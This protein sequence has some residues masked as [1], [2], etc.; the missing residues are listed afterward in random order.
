[1]VN[2]GVDAIV[3][4][5]VVNGCRRDAARQY[6]DAY[7]EYREACRNIE[8]HG[9]IVQHPRTSNPITNPYVPVRDRALRKLQGMRGVNA[10]ELVVRGRGPRHG[11]GAAGRF[12]PMLQVDRGVDRS[13]W[14]ILVPRFFR[15]GRIGGRASAAVDSAV[16]SM[17]RVLIAALAAWWL[18]AGAAL[19]ADELRGRVVGIA[20][21]DTI[22]V[23]DANRQQ[24]RIRLNGID[25][26][27]TAQAF[28]QVSK[29]N[30]STLV[31]GQDVLVVWSKVDRYGRK[32]GAVIRGSVDAN[33]EQLRSGLAWY[34]RQYAGDVAPANRPLYEAAEAEARAAKRGL[35]RDPQPVAPWAFRN[36]SSAPAA[37]PPATPRGLLGTTTSTGLV[38]GNRNS[39]I[40][41][42]PG[43]ADYD[44]VAERNRVYY[45]T[46]AEAVTAGF[47]K[48]RNCK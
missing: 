13:S 44:R 32:I 3:D 46:E 9:V 35:W 48:A 12:H 18:A 43:C 31:F 38:I 45:K 27:E 29:T 28:S 4:T 33:L 22:T 8:A 40:Y 6:A 42:V 2:L 39:R 26:P 21:G 11:G 37:V 16:E 17:R 10:A 24:H 36:P 23:L 1:M 5:L 41:H 30:L 14:P 34:Y 19:S 25:A 47:R 15:I 7:I 20:D